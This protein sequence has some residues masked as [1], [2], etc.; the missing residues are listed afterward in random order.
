MIKGTTRKGSMK[1]LVIEPSRMIEPSRRGGSRRT[2]EASQADARV[3]ASG[4][5]LTGRGK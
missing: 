5:V 1:G 2:V 3:A 4:Q